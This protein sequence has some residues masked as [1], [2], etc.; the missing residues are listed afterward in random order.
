MTFTESGTELNQI[1]YHMARSK[2]AIFIGRDSPDTGLAIYRQIPLK[3]DVF[4]NVPKASRFIP[5]Y[6]FAFVSRYLTILEALAAGVPVLA[7]YNNAIKYDYIS[8]A[9]FAKYIHI[10][11]DPKKVNLKFDLKLVKHGQKWARQQTWDKVVNIY[12]KLWQG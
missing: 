9:P 3:L 1:L 10:F 2:K 5:K 4:T 11:Q 12:E 8:M 7:H 6:D